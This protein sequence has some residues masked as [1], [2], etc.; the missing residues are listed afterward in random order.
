VRHQPVKRCELVLLSRRRA[1]CANLPTQV[2]RGHAV[3]LGS[4]KQLESAFFSE[5][6]TAVQME[7]PQK[8]IGYVTRSKEPNVSFAGDL[9]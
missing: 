6:D 7:Q 8:A 3:R 9:E 2:C 1:I 4:A 5:L